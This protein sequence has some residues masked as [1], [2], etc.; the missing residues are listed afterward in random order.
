MKGTV[1]TTRTWFLLIGAALLISAGLLN[2]SQRARHETPP[3]DGVEWVDTSEGITARSIERGS[4][5]ERAWLL[6]GDRLLGVSLNG[7]AAEQI[8]YARDV[9]IYLEEARVGGQIHYL[10]ERPSYVGIGPY[11]ADLDSLGEIHKWTPRVIYIN[12][13]GLVFLFV[14]FF[15]LFKQGG[16][17]PYALHFATFCLAAFVFLFY[18]PVGSYRDLD[19]A[20]AFLDN[21]AFILFAPLFLHFCA[22][23]PSRQQLFAT[24]RWRAVWLYLPAILLFVFSVVVF[25]RDELGKAFT[26]FRSIPVTEGLVRFFYWICLLHLAV[27]LVASAVLLVRT[28]TTAKSAIVRQQVKWVVWGT[29]LSVTPFTLLYA[30]VYLF[31]APTDRW[32]TDVAILP[33]ALIPF[34]FGYS[35]LRYR[36][37]DVELVVRR[38]FVYALTTLAIALLIGGVVF[39][40]G[41][42]AFGSDQGFT[43]GEITLRVV[44][45]VLAMAA[46]VMVAAPVKNFLQEQVDRVFYG[47]RYDLRN[48]LLDF[49]RTLSATTALDPLL[50]SLVSRLQEVMNVERVAIFI[51]SRNSRSGYEVARAAGLPS[52]I[53]APP[54]FRE[55]IRVRSAETGI[56]RADDIDLDLQSDASVSVRRALHYFVPC[57]VRGRMVAVIGLGRS[58]DGALLS[59]EDV[60]ILRTVSGY[61]AVAIENSLLYKDQQERAGELKHLKEFNESIIESIN[62]GLLAV[63]LGGRVTRLNSALEHILDLRRDAAVGKRVEDLFSEDFADTLKQ[64]LGKE[65]WRLKEIRNIYK[66]HTATRTNRGL[67]LNIALAPLQDAQ[68]QTGALVV[69]E[70]VTARTTLEEQLQQREKLSSIGLLA[71]GVAHEVNTPLTGVSSYTQMLLGMLNENDPKHALLQK[72][73]TQAERATNIV[74]NLLNFSRTGSAT[75]FAE[76]DVARVFDDTLQLLEPQLRRSQIEIVRRYDDDAP[77]VYGNAGKLQQVFTNLILN[78]RD[79]IP[80]G[81]KIIV[82]T[83]TAEDGSLVAEIRDTGIGIAPE[84]VAKIYDPFYTTKGVGRGTGLGLA[85]SYGIIQEHTGRISVDSEPGQG[86]SFR[87]TLPSARV[88]ARLQAVGD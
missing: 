33:L 83:G 65:G 11:W 6:P 56:V 28:F 72:V 22:L 44:V 47:E 70:D 32:L 84:N 7:R 76:I 12:V 19:L 66:L 57:V 58:V 87:I 41:L 10:M 18:T 39:T 74:N 2:F 73:R 15:V 31:G 14:G 54:D 79:A 16:R 35:V 29:L 36:L 61:V 13:I 46:I 37:M 53:F 88:R 75:E 59:S 4:A 1:F 85:V 27:A 62:V 52:Q 43:S 78:A 5:A 82:S 49:G 21:A 42:Y 25:L 64:V 48:S 34:A 71:A 24:R 80:D 9:Q 26:P 81:G 77:E 67:V 68:G 3:W 20:V 17:A 8:Q 38:V 60:E 23:Y 45:V 63:D 69:L 51:E 55:M 86:T 40:G 50:D 30:L